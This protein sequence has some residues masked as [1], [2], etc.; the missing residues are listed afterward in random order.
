MEHRLE[1]QKGSQYLA[2]Q[3]A[4]GIEYRSIGRS[5]LFWK[6]EASANPATAK[7]VIMNVFIMTGL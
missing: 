6:G 1:K 7:V 5:S 4:H 2:T 3:G